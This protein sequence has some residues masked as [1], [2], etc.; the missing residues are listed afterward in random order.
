MSPPHVRSQLFVVTKLFLTA[1]HIRR[2]LAWGRDKITSGPSAWEE[3]AFSDESSFTICPARGRSRVWRR[4]DERF[5]PACLRPSFKSGRPTLSVWAAF[6][7][8]GRT[9]LVR[10][11]GRLNQLKYI[12]IL[13]HHQLPFVEGKHGGIENFILQEDNCGPHRA[14]TVGKYMALHGVRRLDWAPQSPDMNPIENGWSVLERRVRKRSRQPTSL[15]ELFVALSE[16]WDRL[17]DSFMASLW[18]SMP[19]WVAALVQARAHST[20]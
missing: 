6:S 18:G 8:R 10:T 11:D 15:D 12:D 5:L 1:T 17:P 2:R 16:E 14:L 13:L 9:P 7:V 20:K 19:V 4:P 3:V